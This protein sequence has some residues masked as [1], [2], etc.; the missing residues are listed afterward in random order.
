MVNVESAL[1]GV[2]RRLETYKLRYDNIGMRLG[3]IKNTTREQK[4]H[5]DP[6][7]KS[8]WI[9]GTIISLIEEVL[10]NSDFNNAGLVY[11]F[12]IVFYRL[13]HILELKHPALNV[14]F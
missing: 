5:V 8:V 12:Y 14:F 3:T 6:M 9:L 1:G 2:Y 7:Y 13:R 11:S 4:Q 10:N